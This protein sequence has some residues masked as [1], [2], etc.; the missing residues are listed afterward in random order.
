MIIDIYLAHRNSD[1][2]F[3]QQVHLIRKYFKISDGSKMNIIGYVDGSNETIKSQLKKSWE[4]INVK[5]IDIPQFVKGYDRNILGPSESFGLAFQYVY[6]TYISKN[7]HISVCMEND[8]MPFV[9]VNIEEYVKD[10][11]ICGEVRFNARYLPD[12]LLMFWLGFIIF[13]GPLME[14]MELWNAESGQTGKPV[15]SIVTGDVHW[16]D[17]GGNS[18]NWIVKKPR[19]IRNIFTVG[20]ED[21]DPYTSIRCNPFN[22][23]NETHLLPIQFRE[24]YHPSYRVLIYKDLFIHL[25]QMGKYSNIKKE[26]WWVNCFNKIK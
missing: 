9:E 24:N 20:F 6:E 4:L 16:I 13:N 19:K 26:D 15:K 11:E 10:Y 22:I 12:R 8:I 3:A 7:K 21:Y 18:Y 25:E 1:K 2:F 14:D 5:P 17:C 23:T